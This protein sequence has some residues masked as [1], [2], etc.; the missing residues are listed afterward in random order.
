MSSVEDF[1]DQ[2]FASPPGRQ[3]TVNLDIDVNEP[4]ELFEVLLLIMTQGLKKWYGARINIGDVAADHIVKLQEYFLS[5]GIH[6]VVD[7]VAEPGVY[8]IDNKAYLEK[9]KLEEM[10]FTVAANKHLYTVHF[11][12]VPGVDVRW[13]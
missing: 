11:E 4:S 9:K 6:L 7:R 12:F 3:G 1:A 2:L 5:F 10:T 13:S 8:M